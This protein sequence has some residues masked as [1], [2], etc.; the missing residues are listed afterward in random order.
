MASQAVTTALEGAGVDVY[1]GR[2][3]AGNSGARHSRMRWSNR[4][5]V[6]ACWWRWGA[7]ST[8][9]PK[10]LRQRVR[11]NTQGSVVTNAKLQTSNKHIFAAGDCTA[12]SVAPFITL[13]LQV[14]ALIQTCC[15]RPQPR[16]MDP[17]VPIAPIRTL[18]SPALAQ[19]R[20]R[21]MSPACR[22]TRSA[23]I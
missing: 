15:L 5:T 17:I 23:L 4:F 1:V 12:E 18:K 22:T 10:S 19:R 2:R 14:R 3:R 9:R 6:N 8:P 20:T 21:L 16:L 7:S 13:M 11:L